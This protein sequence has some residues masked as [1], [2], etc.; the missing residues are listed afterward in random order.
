MKRIHRLIRL[1]RVLQEG[2]LRSVDDLVRILGVSRRTVFRDLSALEAAGVPA[3]FDR[4]EQGYRLVREHFLPPLSLNFEEALTLLLLSRRAINHKMFPGRLAATSAALKI[5]STLPGE[6]RRRCGELLSAVDLRY[7]PTSEL[8]GTGDLLTGLQHAAAHKRKVAIHYDSLLE[9][10]AIDTVLCPYRLV[11]MRRGWYAI[12][13]SEYHNQVRTFKIER[14]G[15]LRLL[16]ETYTIDEAFSLDD[17]FGDA[18]Q[19]IRGDRKYH[20][21]IR[22]TEKVATNVEEVAWH[23]TQQTRYLPNGALLFEVDVDGLS[24]IVW[25][26]L[27]YGKEAD[28]REPPELRRLVAEHVRALAHQYGTGDPPGRETT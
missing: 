2:E 19:M 18:W 7:W 1:I 21:A 10:R 20:V 9:G 6:L 16:E 14:I 28:V 12:G 25:W 15:E 24:E 11:F 3:T 23:N 22:F 26:I 5:E 4:Q 8:D 17:H 27:G 13:L